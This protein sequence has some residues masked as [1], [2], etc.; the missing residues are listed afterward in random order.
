MSTNPKDMLFSDAIDDSLRCDA[1]LFG[2]ALDVSDDPFSIQL[3]LASMWAR[4]QGRCLAPEDPYEAII[5]RLGSSKGSIPHVG[6]FPLPSWISPRPD[7][8][9]RQLVTQ[10]HMK[11]FLDE[12]GC[13][14][15]ADKIK[16]FVSDQILPD[17]PVMIGIDHSATGGVVWALS[18]ALGPENLTVVVL[19]RHFDALP[20]SLRMEPLLGK[21][22][23]QIAGAENAFPIV[24]DSD[25]Y[26]CGNFWSY[27]IDK[28]V[29]LPENLLFIGVADYPADEVGPEWEAFR[30]A[31]L[32]FEKQGCSF[33]PLKEF[34]GPYEG[35]LNSFL[36]ARITTPYLYVSL[37]LDIGSYRCV[38]AARYM[39]GPGI[40]RKAL[41]HIANA[42][43]RGCRD[44][45]F[46]LCGLD[47]ME[48]NIH[49]LGI[50][51][52]HGVQDMTVPL[53]CD[54]IRAVTALA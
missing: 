22:P 6:R 16:G 14:K 33:F 42:I 21:S 9:D 40:N 17:L 20:L 28:G 34:E 12:D 23:H 25:L 32:A 41:M 53:A 35:S 1:R 43:A 48:F 39:D 18:D 24:P 38:H 45:R 10:E 11:K 13:L 47:V 26:C 37:D 19:D 3:K 51:G 50:T 49:L 31:Y 54:F 15:L 30:D 27:L 52:K 8:L 2:V 4:Q 44:G 29:I 46:R 36:A 5:E 7:S